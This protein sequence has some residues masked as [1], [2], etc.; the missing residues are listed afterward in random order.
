MFKPVCVQ[1]TYYTQQQSRSYL[2]HILSIQLDTLDLLKH[3]L[4]IHDLLCVWQGPGGRGAW[5]RWW[6]EWL[7]RLNPM[8]PGLRVESQGFTAASASATCDWGAQA[9]P[10]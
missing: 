8:R 5:L 3:L 7:R 2:V 1:Y 10:D 6:M 4:H 9:G